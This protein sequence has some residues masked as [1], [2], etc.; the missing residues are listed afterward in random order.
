MFKDKKGIDINAYKKHLVQQKQGKSVSTNRL[1]N[2]SQVST[3]IGR[4][5]SS[6]IDDFILQRHLNQPELIFNQCRY[7]DLYFEQDASE[8]WQLQ[9]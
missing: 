7:K 5:E 4:I 8:Q 2:Q 1:I 6:L 9:D 3:G